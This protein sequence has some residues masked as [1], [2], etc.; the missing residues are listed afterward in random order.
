VLC[1]RRAP[2]AMLPLSPGEWRERRGREIPQREDLISIPLEW[3]KGSAHQGEV[4]PA[5]LSSHPQD[6]LADQ[7]IA[8]TE[9]EHFHRSAR[10]S[11]GHEQFCVMRGTAN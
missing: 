2:L 1:H 11:C 4:G 7:L 10:S 8:E 9:K 3:G 6:H 5:T